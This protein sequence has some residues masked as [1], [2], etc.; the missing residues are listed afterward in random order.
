MRVPKTLLG[1]V[2]LWATSV[3]SVVQ[4][5]QTD[6]Q[7]YPF[8]NLVGRW[9][10]SGEGFGSVSQVT[11][12]WQFVIDGEFLQLETHSVAT[13]ADG[14]QE[15]H[16]DVGYLSFDADEQQFV[17]RQFLSEGF[18]NTYDVPVTREQL[19]HIEF[20]YRESESS[21][22]MRARL[23][24]VFSGTDEYEMVLDLANPGEDFVACQWMRMKRVSGG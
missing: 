3:A 21:G 10:G 1:L 13:A 5:Q 12:N 2:L 20:L 11:H 14:S 18:V 4:A 19:N 16:E 15:F 22:G 6:D 17:F 8:R 9:E 23:H 24:L 7:W